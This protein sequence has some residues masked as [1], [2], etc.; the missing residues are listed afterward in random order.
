[1]IFEIARSSTQAL[2]FVRSEFMFATIVDALYWVK[3]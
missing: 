1:M 3:L 2:A